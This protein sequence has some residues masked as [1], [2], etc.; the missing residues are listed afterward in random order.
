LYVHALT[1]IV[2]VSN[3]IQVFNLSGITVGTMSGVF[4]GILVGLKSRK[5]WA[6][7]LGAVSGGLIGGS[8]GFMFPELASIVGGIIGGA[9]SGGIGGTLAAGVGKRLS[10]WEASNMQ[11]AAAMLKGAGMGIVVGGVV[12]GLCAFG[13][14]AGANIFAGTSPGGIVASPIRF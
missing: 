3:P 4:G 7:I 13:I 14:K 8:V 5:A 6:S 2:E 9:I 1:H 11:M 12:G 10:Q